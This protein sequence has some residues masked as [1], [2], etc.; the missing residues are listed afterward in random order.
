MIHYNSLRQS[1]TDEDLDFDCY[2]EN[3]EIV[4]HFVQYWLDKAKKS[5]SNSNAM[6][7]TQATT[8]KINSIKSDFEF[9]VKEDRTCAQQKPTSL[10]C[11]LYMMSFIDQLSTNQKVQRCIK[12]HQVMKARKHILVDL[13]NHDFS[14]TREQEA[15]I[16]ISQQLTSIGH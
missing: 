2:W 12:D 16:E 4:G 1:T 6:D 9:Q 5:T 8:K 14:W 13:M 11:G 7:S 15:Y 10:D 3:A